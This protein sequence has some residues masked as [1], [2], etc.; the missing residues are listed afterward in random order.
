MRMNFYDEVELSGDILSG[1]TRPDPTPLLCLQVPSGGHV[2]FLAP[3]LVGGDLG[4]LGGTGWE[5]RGLSRPGRGG[6]GWGGGE[7][8]KAVAV[9]ASRC[10]PPQPGPFPLRP[11][12]PAVVPLFSP[13]S[14]PAPTSASPFPV[15]CPALPSTSASLEGFLQMK[16][17]GKNQRIALPREG[18]QRPACP[19][20]GPA[21]PPALAHPRS[22]SRCLGT[23]AERR[24]YA[25]GGSRRRC[26]RRGTWGH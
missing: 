7:Q 6:R 4:V 24:P 25:P 14:C 23:A 11:A 3:Q 21:G 9:A 18:R 8:G 26:G 13:S 17:K 16:E 1:G 5:G 15:S 20:P 22:D 12:L 19:L 10:G 2:V